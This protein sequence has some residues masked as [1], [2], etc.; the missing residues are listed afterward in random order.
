VVQRLTITPTV[1]G[2]SASFVPS[3]PQG[4]FIAYQGGAGTPVASLSL[5]QIAG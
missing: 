4:R 2:C 1:V 3:N 5:G